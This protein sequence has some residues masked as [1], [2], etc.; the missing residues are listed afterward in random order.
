MWEVAR[1]ARNGRSI[2]NY[3]ITKASFLLLYKQCIEKEPESFKF[4]FV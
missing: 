3:R 4:Q 1:G 2:Q